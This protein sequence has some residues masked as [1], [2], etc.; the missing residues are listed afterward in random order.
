MRKTTHPARRKHLHFPQV[1]HESPMVP[2]SLETN[3]DSHRQSNIC[4]FFSLIFRFIRLGSSRFKHHYAMVIFHY[5][6][7]RA[8]L[9]TRHCLNQFLCSRADHPAL[10]GLG[11]QASAAILFSVTVKHSQKIS[12]EL[13]FGPVDNFIHVARPKIPRQCRLKQDLGKTNTKQS[14]HKMRTS[15]KKNVRKPTFQG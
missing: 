6:A 14:R 8:P 5:L 11:T 2:N 15:D 1:G 9:L 12:G 4:A 13:A 7:F 10:Q 3:Q